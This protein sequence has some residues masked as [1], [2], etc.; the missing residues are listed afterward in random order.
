MTDTRRVLVPLPSLGVV[1][2][3][4]T[5]QAGKRNRYNTT[6]GNLTAT[7]PALADTPFG[8]RLAVQKFDDSTHTV[9]VQVAS[10]DLISDQGTSITISLQMEVVELVV[11]NDTW[12]VCGHYLPHDVGALLTTTN[13]QTVSGKTLDGGVNTFTNVPVSALGTGSVTGQTTAGATS[14]KLWTGTAAEYA[15]IA[16]KD[17]NTIYVATP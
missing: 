5:L 15:A 16:V 10:G 17:A 7:L 8:A 13:T 11:G 12:E 9:T 4:S 6:A 14:L 1:S 2:A 3:S